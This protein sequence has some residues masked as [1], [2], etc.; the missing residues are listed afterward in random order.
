MRIRFPD[1]N[2]YSCFAAA[3]LLVLAAGTGSLPRCCAPALDDLTIARIEPT[4]GV[5]NRDTIVEI[6]GT[7][8]TENISVFFGEHE[9][10]VLLL[11][12]SHPVGRIIV[13]APVLDR[14]EDVEVRVQD[15]CNPERFAVSYPSE[16]GGFRY[17]F[18]VLAPYVVSGVVRDSR[19]DSAIVGARVTVTPGGFTGISGMEGGYTLVLASGGVH[20]VRVSAP[21]FETQTLV[22]TIPVVPTIHEVT[23][24]MKPLQPQPSDSDGD[25]LLDVDEIERY[26]TDPHS[27]DT[28][29]DGF[30][31][32][33]EVGVGLDPLDF[34]DADRTRRTDV[35]RSGAV[36]AVDVQMAV[37]AALSAGAI[38]GELGE[39][40][41]DI[42][43]DGS[44]N[45]VD[46]QWVINAALGRFLPG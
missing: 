44:V 40:S 3:V 4:M 29:T 5:Q 45:A 23:F 9:A 26:G 39:P 41:P 35:D 36:D 22:T 42:D 12:L 15:R 31:D 13:R 30:S 8:F 33:D 7:G 1:T 10:R 37:N 17:I 6:R 34:F 28:D 24:R 20:T 19:D 2:A 16:G 43:L 18:S 38:V 46:I 21:G 11:D 14:V 27:A 25:G 32:G